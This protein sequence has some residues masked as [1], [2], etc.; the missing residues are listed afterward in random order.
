MMGF[1]S[2]S[3][4]SPDTGRQVPGRRL[5]LWCVLCV[6]LAVLGVYLGIWQWGRAADKQA[7]LEAL[8]EAP[9]IEAP[10][11][12]PVDGAKL[13]LRGRFEAEQTLFLDNV[14]HDGH[15]GV[16]VLTP[17]IDEI[18]QRWLVDR[19]FLETGVSRTDPAASTP[20]SEAVIEG[21]WQAA[22]DQAPVFGNVMEGKRLQ[23]I[24]P[25]A[26]AEPFSWAGWVHQEKGK[27]SLPYWWVASVLPP[28][29]HLAY[30]F[31]WWGLTLV[32]LVALVVGA[33]R[34]LMDKRV[35]IRKEGCRAVSQ[36]TET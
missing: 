12:E 5:V 17:F 20:G 36:T 33:R 26:W 2:G 13:L 7:Y 22:G 34:L 32:A 21:R 14:T 30:A 18:G 9:R 6:S 10:K 31:Q 11:A 23:R 24:E 8:A 25:D 1:R 19:G 28:E 29:R 3:K 15:L 35:R 16:A 4:S 27:G